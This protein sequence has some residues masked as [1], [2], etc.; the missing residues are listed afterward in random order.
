MTRVFLYSNDALPSA[1]KWYLDRAGEIE[2]CDDPG[3]AQV[4]LIYTSQWSRQT[5]SGIKSLLQEAAP[6]VI[7]CDNA[8][9]PFARDSLVRG[10]VA[11][12]LSSRATAEQIVAGVRA[13]AAG[14]SVR[15]RAEAVCPVME[16][17]SL[18]PRELEVLRLIADGEGNKSIAY[19]LEISQHTVKFHISSIFEKLHAFSRTEAVKAGITRGLVSI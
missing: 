18:T 11:G 19:I 4:I 17:T 8:E 2:L 6:A 1:A 16:D 13:A 12:V 7:L 3:S 5:L 10:E 9:E 14:L 15:Q